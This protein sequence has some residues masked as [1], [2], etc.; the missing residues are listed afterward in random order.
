MTNKNELIDQI[1]RSYLEEQT[2][3]PITDREEF[4]TRDAIRFACEE[5]EAAYGA[6]RTGEIP[7]LHGNGDEPVEY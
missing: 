7:A 4:L 1:T 2:P 3:Y 6:G 5:M